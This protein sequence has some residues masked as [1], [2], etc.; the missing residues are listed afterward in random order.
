M[1]FKYARQA[2]WRVIYI[3]DDDPERKEYLLIFYRRKTLHEWMNDAKS[4]TRTIVRM[5][6]AYEY[7]E[8]TPISY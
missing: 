4:S 3:H 7:P 6:I 8:Y 1:D 2:K 5:T